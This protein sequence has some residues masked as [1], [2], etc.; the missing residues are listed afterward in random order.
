MD[1]GSVMRQRYGAD[2]IDANSSLDRKLDPLI[3]H[4]ITELRRALEARIGT[5][6]LSGRWRFGRDGGCQL[7]GAEGVEKSEPDRQF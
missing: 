3:Q 6:P 7:H 4:R 5:G 2:L 1:K